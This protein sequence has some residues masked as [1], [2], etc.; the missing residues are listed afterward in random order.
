MT[1][2]LE[3]LLARAN[4]LLK[5][6]LSAQYPLM[7]DVVR[8]LAAALRECAEDAER[9]RYLRSWKGQW[10]VVREEPEDTQLHGDVLDAAIDA[11]RREGKGKIIDH[12]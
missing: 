1:P 11:A 6:D 5:N 3:A 10:I 8:D 7:A 9:Y 2:E 4:A 12:P